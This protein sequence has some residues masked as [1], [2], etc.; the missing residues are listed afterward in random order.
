MTQPN[1]KQWSSNTPGY[2]IFLVDQ[3]GSM[4]SPYSG[5]QNRA[6]FTA[7][8]INRVINEIIENNAHGATVKNRTFISII[9]YGGQ[10]GVSVENLRSDY[11][12]DFANNPLRIEKMQKQ[13]SDGAGGLVSVDIEMAIHVE[14]VANGLTPM[15]KA[16]EEAKQLIEAWI[17]KKPDNPAPVVINISDGIPYEA[18]GAEPQR[19]IQAAN[20]IMQ[21][22]TA[23]GSPLIFNA[24]IGNGGSAKGFEESE[25][26]LGSNEEAKLLFKISSVVPDAY[27]VAAK[28]SGFEVK[29]NSRAFVS[30]AD[31]ITLISF[32]DFGSSGGVDKG[33]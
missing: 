30:N 3:S 11:L 2:L 6:T 22:S 1:S 15:G 28:K 23:D 10:G 20:E 33:V 8:A 32:I 19:T 18:T 9:G 14:A 5:S 25:S 7:L 4:K 29:A 17:Q 31:P 27:K 26:E 24:H 13:V 12:Q 16:F 21:L